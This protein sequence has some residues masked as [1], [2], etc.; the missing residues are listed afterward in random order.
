LPG[1]ALPCS[2][3]APR[4]DVLPEL[5]P[6][7]LA[8]ELRP[9]TLWIIDTLDHLPHLEASIGTL[10]DSVRTIICEQLAQDRAHGRQAFRHR[11]PPGEIADAYT[12]HRF[13]QI[14]STREILCR[15]RQE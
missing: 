13:R 7:R 6:G 4:F 5:L 14:A 10:L 2:G 12:S 9:D 15:A 3:R 11:R 8:P 1:Y